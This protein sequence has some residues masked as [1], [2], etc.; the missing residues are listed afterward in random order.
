MNNT[1]HDELEM[2][3][4]LYI[5]IYIQISHTHTHPYMLPPMQAPFPPPRSVLWSTLQSH[6]K[7]SLGKVHRDIQPLAATK[8]IYGFVL[9]WTDREKK[10]VTSGIP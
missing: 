2:C 9:Q 6:G 3:V 1:N 4:R 5:Y 7:L 10:F 8:G